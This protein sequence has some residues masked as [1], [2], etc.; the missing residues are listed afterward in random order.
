MELRRNGQSPDRV[1]A[2]Y[3]PTTPSW[4]RL[5]VTSYTTRTV[6]SSGGR[7]TFFLAGATVGLNYPLM[8]LREVA[9][10]KSD[11][12]L[13]RPLNVSEKFPLVRQ[14]IV[15]TFCGDNYSIL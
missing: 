15:L 4:E 8:V 14:P 3:T 1:R 11:A 9:C 12:P 10:H 7:Q 6:I 5:K 13:V 2:L